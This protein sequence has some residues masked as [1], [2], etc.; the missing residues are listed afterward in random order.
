ML[1]TVTRVAGALAALV[2]LAL[3]VLG[4]WF[5]AALGGSGTAEFTARPA[6]GAPVVIQSVI[7]RAVIGASKMPL[8]KCAVATH[9]P[10]MSGQGPSTGRLSGAHGRKPY[11]VRTIG[12]APS[13]GTSAIAVAHP[14][15]ERV[16]A[17]LARLK[18]DKL[19]REHAK[20]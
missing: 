13:D 19:A 5:A 8:R 7:S 18:A 4:V 3:T 9:R 17:A 6:A 12:N 20:K 14:D 11:Q 10:S 2:G 16:L 15:L 1:R